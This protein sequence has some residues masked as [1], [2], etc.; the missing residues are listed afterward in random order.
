MTAP[1]PAA[2]QRALLTLALTLAVVFIA[3]FAMSR[4]QGNSWDLHNYHLYNGWAFWTGRS[5]D[6][7]VAQLQTYFN[8]LL[9]AASY[10][11]FVNTPPWLSAFALGLV[12]AANLLPLCVLAL[13]LLRA[14]RGRHWLALALAVIGVC[15]AASLSELGGSMGDNLVSLPFLA[16]CALVFTGEPRPRRFALAALL[17]GAAA[18]IKLTMAPYAFGL[19]LAMPWRA[20]DF[21]T[22]RRLAVIA[23]ISMTVGFF[24]CDGFWMLRLWREFGNPLHPMFASLFGGDFVP[25]YSLRDAR[26]PPDTWN[27]WIAYPLVWA[28]SPHRV[29]ELWFLDLRVPLAFLALPFLLWPTRRSEADDAARL[30]VQRLLAFAATAA[31]FAW[32]VLFGYYRYLATLEMLSPLLLALTLQRWLPPRWAMTALLITLATIACTTRAPNWG[33]IKHYENDFLRIDVPKSPALAGATVVFAE[34]EPLSFLALGFP[35]STQFVR[36]SGNNMGTP[37]PEYG[38]DRAARRHLDEATGPFFALIAHPDDPDLPAALAQHDFQLRPPCQEVK[39]N[40][41][42]ANEHAYLCEL[43]R[44]RK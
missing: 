5:H 28:S 7:A 41:I 23:L 8:P 9:P 17:A 30:R 4:G 13:G 42:T 19:L 22:R 40:L 16:A 27:E 25:P 14:G 44:T 11:L 18:G 34:N 38:M 24:A 21:P 12:Q 20:S 1:T 3:V 39:S 33:R 6:F 10:L 31:Y 26:W 29:S 35:A 2:T 37:W 43:N 36:I 32:L 15:G